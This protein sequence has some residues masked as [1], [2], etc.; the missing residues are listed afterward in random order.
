M[1][2]CLATWGQFWKCK[3]TETKQNSAMEKPKNSR[4]DKCDRTMRF[5]QEPK[6]APRK[7][8][9]FT[10]VELHKHFSNC[11]APRALCGRRET[12]LAALKLVRLITPRQG[13]WNADLRTPPGPEGSNG[14]LLCIRRGYPGFFQF[15][16]CDLRSTISP[17]THRG[18]DS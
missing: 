17:G 9:N 13:P 1:Q 4:L 2:R 3:A 11:I 12:N 6:R 8:L 10:G 5:G 15:T 16:N 18:T 14:S 7:L